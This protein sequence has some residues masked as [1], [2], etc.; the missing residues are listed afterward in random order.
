M[1]M[2]IHLS[3]YIY[4]NLMISQTNEYALRAMI[5]LTKN[6][7][8]PQTTKQIAK[9]MKI[10]VDYLAKILQILTR[11]E[12]LSSQRGKS[13]GY[14]VNK[15]PKKISPLDIIMAVDPIRSITCC[16]IGLKAHKHNLCPMHK[17]IE[18]AYNLM[19]DAFRSCN[20][21]ELSS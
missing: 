18:S 7:G 5:W 14:K 20:L 17:K 8:K 12:I 10:P 1:D 4:K 21:E 16:P 19:K 9:E 3:S 15:D 13:G 6:K 2:F 11:N